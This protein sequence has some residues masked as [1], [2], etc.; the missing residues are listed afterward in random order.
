MALSLLPKAW[1]RGWG[2]AW[3]VD[4]T[5]GALVSGVL[6]CLACA[7]TLGFGYLVFAQHRMGEYSAMLIA[8][9]AELAM[10][11]K[12]MQ[13]ATGMVTLL[14]YLLHPVSVALMYFSFEGLVR[15]AAALVTGEVVGSMPLYV[16]AAAQ[17]GM[18]RARAERA[19]GPRIA[20]EVQ[21]GDGKTC[22]YRILSCRPKPGWNHLIT[23]CFQDELYEVAQHEHGPGPRP[24]IYL[25]RPAPAHKIVR[26]LEQYD[27]EAVLE[28]K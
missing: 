13:Y 26:G 10:A 21:P 2:T 27:P 20:D 8:K 19:M 7:I 24:Y 14:E 12:G 5:R 18:S 4:L 3:E 16:A 25:L 11:D 1:R 22:A 6:Q 17:Q 23:V 15:F 28:K 9:G